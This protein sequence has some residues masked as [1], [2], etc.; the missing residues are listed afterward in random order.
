MGL[1]GV[2][3]PT[4][5]KVWAAEIDASIAWP[6]RQRI[7]ELLEKIARL[8][9]GGVIDGEVVRPGPQRALPKPNPDEGC[10]P[11]VAAARAAARSGKPVSFQPPARP[12]EPW[13]EHT[14]AYD[15]MYSTG[16][17]WR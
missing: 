2:T 14:P 6:L 7:N 16:G 12:A 17:G 4:P 13:R 5:W 1:F 3:I 11:D 9:S 10:S 15:G 8:E